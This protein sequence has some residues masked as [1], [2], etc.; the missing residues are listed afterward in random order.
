MAGLEQDGSGAGIRG[1]LFT[2]TGTPAISD[3]AAAGE[4]FRI[5]TAFW[6]A[7]SVPNICV[8]GTWLLAAWEDES[9]EDPDNSGYAVRLRLLPSP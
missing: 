3:L 1:R 6:D 9:T 7:Q 5:N 2:A 8:T 4:D